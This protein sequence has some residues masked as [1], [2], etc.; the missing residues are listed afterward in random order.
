M[1][2]QWLLAYL[3]LGSVVGFFAG[4]FGIGGGGIMV[5]VLTTLFAVQGM[6]PELIVHAAL[7]TSLAAIIATSISSLRAH[8][9]LGAVNWV[10]VRSITPGILLGSFAATFLAAW[11]SSLFLA[12]FFVLFMSYVALQMLFDIKPRPGRTL[13]G[14]LGLSVAG[15]VIGAISSLVAIG[16]GTMTVPFLSWC[17]VRIQNA[18]GTSAAV[19]LPIAMAGTLG[20]FVSGLNASGMPPWSLGFV[21]APAAVLISLMSVISA[22]LGARL[23]HRLPVASLKKLFA[24]LLIVLAIKMLHTV[25]SS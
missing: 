9:R 10:V 3:A 17:N 14:A 13:P 18:I 20:Y 23:V 8:H 22:P 7:A 15:L 4:L 1:A 19:G 12:I 5:P 21:Y 24:A 16:G 2:L 25:Q 11:L 6:P